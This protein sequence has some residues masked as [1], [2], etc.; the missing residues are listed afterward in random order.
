M[1]ILNRRLG[2]EI[3]IGDDVRIRVVDIRGTRVK[4]GCTGP[5]DVTIERS[6]LHER[7]T[8]EAAAAER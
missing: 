6:E 4:L 8:R 5:R 7:R 3:V 1:L 2:E